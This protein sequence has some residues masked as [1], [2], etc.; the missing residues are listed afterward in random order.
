MDARFSESEFSAARLDIVDYFDTLVN[1]IDI[2]AE[3][4][5]TLIKRKLNNAD[6]D[7][8]FVL[9]QINAIRSKFVDKIRAIQVFNLASLDCNKENCDN[10]LVRLK[11][12]DDM[13]RRNRLLLKKFAFYLNRQSLESF[14]R[15][16]ILGL[17]VIID[18]Y[19]D[20]SELDVLK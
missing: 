19:L 1:Q 9:R 11:T 10:N 12:F 18:W 4:K 5:I 6:N 8:H 7:D 20:E 15:N 3:T 16:S 17:L 14:S 2:E 13:H